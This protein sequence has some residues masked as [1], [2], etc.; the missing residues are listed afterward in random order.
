MECTGGTG[1]TVRIAAR[2]AALVAAGA[3]VVG[4]CVA[5]TDLGAPGPGPT[6][7]PSVSPTAAATHVVA[8]PGRLGASNRAW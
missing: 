8:L 5:A 6:V 4:G 1:S 7:S 3:A 2:A